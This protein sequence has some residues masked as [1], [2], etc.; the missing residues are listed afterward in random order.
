MELCVAVFK[1]PLDKFGKK[2]SGKLRK[3][4]ITFLQFQCTFNFPWK[5]PPVIFLSN[6]ERLH[7]YWPRVRL[8]FQPYIYQESKF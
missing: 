2:R 3:K 8:T 5:G 1:E 6:D 4:Y 7:F